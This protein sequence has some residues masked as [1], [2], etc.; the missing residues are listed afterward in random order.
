MGSGVRKNKAPSFVLLFAVVGVAVVL[1]LASFSYFQSVSQQ[2]DATVRE[3]LRRQARIEAFQVTQLLQDKIQTVA[4]NARTAAQASAIINGEL[5]RGADVVNARQHNTEEITD[6]YIW[7]NKDGK[8]VWSSA[9]EMNNTEFNLYSGYDVS[10]RPYFSI[11]AQTGKPYLSPVVQSP[12]DKSQ[13]MF[14]AYP[15]SSNDISKS[16]LGNDFNGVV[17]ASLRATNVGKLVQSQLSSDLESSLGIIDPNGVIVYTANSTFIG[18]NL[19]GQKVQSLLAPAF[20]SQTEVDQF[21]DFLRASLK[22]GKDSKDF[23][24]RAGPTSTITYLPILISTDSGASDD[25]SS[26]FLTL[27]LTAPHNIADKVGPLIAQE[28]NLSLAV[29]STISGITVAFLY[30]VLS[31]NKRLERTVSD[32]TSSLKIANESLSTTNKELVEKSRQLESANEQLTI[33]EKMQREFINIAAHELRTPTQAII[34]FSELFELRPEER[35]ESMKAVAR[36]ATRLERLTN[37]ILDVTKIEGKS[38]TLNKEK[39]NISEVISAAVDDAK[40]QIANGEIRL[41]YQEPNEIL[42]EGD[43]ER[44]TQVISNLLSNA[45]KF[46]K[47]GSIFVLSE[48]KGNEV[49]VSV[50]DSGSGIDPEIQPRL[51]TKFTSKSQ[52]GTGLGLFI[53]RSIIEAHGGKITGTNNKEGAGATFTFTLPL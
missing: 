45:I 12:V 41:I 28:R 52:T 16:N 38:L 26:H 48:E 11:P 44:I 53:S 14:I 50:V 33:N 39:F 8:T 21:N 51:F 32:R 13:R 34:G 10:Q 3:D 31:W 23:A 15:V 2:I 9:F 43:K 46:T 24:G 29:I 17:V 49:V 20:N 6:R 30:V 19:F 22:G 47:K 18:E 36:N 25:K 40:R 27:Y 37:D 35:E 5:E 1:S 4:T 7:I 42:V